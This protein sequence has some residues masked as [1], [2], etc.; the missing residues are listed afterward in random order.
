MTTLFLQGFTKIFSS[1]NKDIFD[2]KVAFSALAVGK[3]NKV[4]HQVKTVNYRLCWIIFSLV[5]QQP[6]QGLMAILAVQND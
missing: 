4:F 3:H 5:E 1:Q 2:Q 6:L